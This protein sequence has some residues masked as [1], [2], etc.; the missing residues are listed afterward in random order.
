MSTAYASEKEAASAAITEAL[1]K[2]LGKY[3]DNPKHKELLKKAGYEFDKAKRKEQ[4]IANL[5]Y[6]L[7]HWDVGTLN[8][9]KELCLKHSDLQ[10]FGSS[11]ELWE[12]VERQINN[13]KHTAEKA[14]VYTKSFIEDMRVM[15]RSVQMIHEFVGSGG[16][17]AQK[18][19]LMGSLSAF[20]ESAIRKLESIE[21]QYMFTDYRWE[22]IFKS[23][24]PVRDFVRRMHELEKENKDLKAQLAPKSDIGKQEKSIESQTVP[25]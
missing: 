2:K 17:H 14:Q 24:Y 25:F 23:E 21:V 3:L 15:F 22:N 19:A 9:I 20:L 7:I 8:K 1:T 5:V 11:G 4:A 18:E 10:R 16:T 6:T 13:Y 12:Q